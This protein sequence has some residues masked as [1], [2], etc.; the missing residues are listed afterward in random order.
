MVIVSFR[1]TMKGVEL[2]RWALTG[3]VNAAVGVSERE[4]AVAFHKTSAGESDVTVRAPTFSGR[5][6]KV[7]PGTI[8]SRFFVAV[9]FRILFRDMVGVLLVERRGRDIL[10]V[11]FVLP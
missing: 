3:I 5:A 9:R 7:F 8:V 11:L 6:G 1:P 4:R 2:R 10:F